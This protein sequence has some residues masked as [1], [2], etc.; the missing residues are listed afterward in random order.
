MSRYRTNNL[1]EAEEVEI[2]ACS[3]I[4]RVA[5]ESGVD[6]EFDYLV[7][8]DLWPVGIGQRVEVPFGRKNKLQTGFCAEADIPFEDSFTGRGRGRTLK[9]V[10][11]VI[12]K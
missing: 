4:I 8:D 11:R 10:A 7:P 2:T 5:F 12:D 1:F 9:K 3:H 6:T